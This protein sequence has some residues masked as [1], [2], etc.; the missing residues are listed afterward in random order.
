MAMEKTGKSGRKNRLVAD[1]SSD[2]EEQKSGEENARE[3]DE[4]GRAHV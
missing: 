2:L 1:Q 3:L 4:I